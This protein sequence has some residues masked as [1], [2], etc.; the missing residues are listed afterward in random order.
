[1]IQLCIQ[2]LLCEF[3]Y[4]GLRFVFT[5]LAYI[6][7]ISPWPHPAVKSEAYAYDCL[8][9]VQ[10]CRLQAVAAATTTESWAITTLGMMC[11]LPKGPSSRKVMVGRLAWILA[12]M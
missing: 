1:M 3:E 8:L 10:L 6:V 2:F 9:H 11:S 5:A 7:L 4:K 12:H